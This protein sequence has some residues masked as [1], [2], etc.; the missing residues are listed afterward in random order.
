M[1]H[2]AIETSCD[3][4]SV[5][6]LED[7]RKIHAN[8]VSTQIPVH[9]L[10][11]GVVPEIAS[12]KHLETINRLLDMVFKESKFGPEDME[13]VSVTRGPGL[14]GALLVGIS[15]AKALAYVRNIPI[16]G[17][18]HM[19]GHI[20]ANYLSNPGLEPP[21]ASLV[22]SGGHTYLV[23]V[24]D[25]SHYQVLGQTF[26]DACGES[27]DKISR[28]LGMGYPGGPKIQKL[29]EEGD[30]YSLDFP[31]AMMRRED[32]LNFSFSGLKTAVINYCHNQEQKGEELN[33][34]NVAAS[35]QKAVIDVLTAKSEM[36]LDQ[37]G[38]KTFCLSGGVAANE[39]LRKSLAK[40]CKA[41]G[42][43]FN[44]PGAELCTDN[45]AMIGAAGYLQYKNSGSDNLDFSA[46]PKLGL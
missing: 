45:A 15:A 14:L 44:Y 8:L 23:R 18:N 4:T 26:D 9:A 37:S 11:G 34:A 40:M 6:I 25:Y 19:Q 35:F 20:C 46:D 1:I 33:K 36:L 28:V 41:K 3:E 38:L 16:V 17:A 12:R 43:A 7:C 31:R 10:Y 21:F 22:V 24:D 27:F 39:P 32:G 13:L 2:L 29:A 42:V 5:A 30:P